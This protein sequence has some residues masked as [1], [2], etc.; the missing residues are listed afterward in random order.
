[1]QLDPQQANRIATGVIAAQLARVPD[2]QLVKL[3]LTNPYAF[4]ASNTLDDSLRAVDPK[5]AVPLSTWHKAEDIQERSSNLGIT[6]VSFVDANY[7]KCL[8][9]IPDPPPVLHVRGTPDI[10][11]KAPGVAVVG[12]RQASKVGLEIAE[13][14]GRFLSESGWIV[15][16]GLAIGIDQ[17]A[18][19]GCMEGRTPTL[20]VLAHGLHKASPK[21]N[22]LL[23]MKILETG[24]A[25]ISEHPIGVEPRKHFFVPRNRIQTGLSAASVIVEAG[26]NSG[27]TSQARFCLEQGRPLFAVVPETIENA[28]K[29]HAEGTSDLVKKKRAFPIRNRSDYANLLNVLEI[30]KTKIVQH[31]QALDS[32]LSETVH[33]VK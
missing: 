18:H 5:Y 25:W 13:R 30:S 21:T 22:E 19:K 31:V 33:E 3:S 32:V 8:R 11:A 17:A 24:G 12:T 20:A 16:S 27:S 10:L 29:L 14:L 1:M 2:R 7:P 4:L 28:L 26:L 15:V 9:V 23:G 6:V